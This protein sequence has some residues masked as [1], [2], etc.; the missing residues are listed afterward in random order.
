MKHKSKFK[1]LVM[2][3]MVVMLVLAPINTV[4]ATEQ[5]SQNLTQS[6]ARIFVNGTEVLTSHRD[7]APFIINGTTYLPLPALR[8]A[9]AEDIIW[10]P[11]TSSIYLNNVPETEIFAATI[12]GE[13]YTFTSEELLALGTQDFTSVAGNEDFT[14]IPFA[15]VISEL[16]YDYSGDFSNYYLTFVGGDGFIM[17]IGL[18]EALDPEVTFIVFEDSRG[19]FRLILAQDEARGRWVRGNVLEVLLEASETG[20]E[21]Q[22]FNREISIIANGQEITPTDVL[23]NTVSPFMLDGM[24]YMPLRAVAEALDVAI[25]WDGN[26]NIIFIGDK[27]A[28]IDSDDETEFTVT[29]GSQTYTVTMSE[30]TALDELRDFHATARG[31]RRDFTGVPIAAILNNL[32]INPLTVVENVTFTAADGNTLAVPANEIINPNYG[33][34]AI[35]ESG[36]ELSSWE[37]GGSGPFRLIL[38]QDLFPQRWVSN[39]V[40]I[41]LVLGDAPV[42]FSI[43]SQGQTQTVTMSDISGLDQITVTWQEDEYTGVPL[44]ALFEHFNV[45]YSGGH[46]V[47]LR[48]VDGF[49]AVLSMEE[50]LDADNTFVVFE[51]NG[52]PVTEDGMFASIMAKD[53]RRNRFVR[54]LSTITIYAQGSDADETEI[55][56]NEF[57]IIAKG[58]THIVTIDIIE[59]IGAKDFTATA[60]GRDRN[61]TGVSFVELLEYFEIDYSATTTVRFTSIDGLDHTWTAAEAFDSE[62][63]FIAFLEDGEPLGDRDRP[64]RSILVGSSANRWIGQVQIITLN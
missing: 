60:E 9:L 51:R 18:D 39:I 37:T 25:E 10:R 7:N 4:M 23:G 63:A 2:L 5:T 12:G 17:P 64:F 6:T 13:T 56:E 26:R 50:A 36:V 40:N 55:G 42:S 29:A 57:A 33:F 30:F 22:I 59:S 8:T 46:E 52:E 38:A 47:T 15:A 28:V 61:F 31:E 45:N 27:P 48:S 19:T 41:A 32:G 11:D 35:A 16:D 58:Q 21:A 24:I 1:S 20:G 43:S 49:N 34:L 53:A 54:Q 44:A 62:K 3:L 14:G